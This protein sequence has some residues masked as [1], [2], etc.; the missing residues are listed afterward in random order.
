MTNAL[1]T[2]EHTDLDSRSWIDVERS[3][4]PVELGDL[5]AEVGRHLVQPPPITVYGRT[6][7]VPR[8]V[9][10]IGRG[11]S[12]SSRYSREIAVPPIE[13]H[14]LLARITE[15]ARQ[16]CHADFDSVLLN[17]YRDGH[18]SVGWHA[19]DERSIRGGEPIAALSL[20]ETRRLRVRSKRHLITHAF[21]LDHG[22]LL[23][24][25]GDMQ[26]E[27]QHSVPKMR[28]DHPRLSLTF[29]VCA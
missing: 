27:W 25:G 7:P 19:D 13:D 28:A 11:F 23:V 26:R 21:Q 18:D 6:Y 16:T 22:D 15:R 20:G 5:L 1:T 9:A 17:Y 3:W 4:C 10:W 2:T 12:Q 8:L 29:R 14:P 24:M